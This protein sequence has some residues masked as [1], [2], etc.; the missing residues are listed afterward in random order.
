M[1]LVYV[2]ELAFQRVIMLWLC[3]SMDL[4]LQEVLGAEG[5]S[6]QFRHIASHLIW[7]CA[8]PTLP[9]N[10]GKEFADAH[11]ELLNEVI[12]VTG[13]FAVENNDNQVSEI[14]QS[15]FY[16]TFAVSETKN[17]LFWALV[18]FITH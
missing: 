10:S 4:L 11:Q 9:K 5:I 2:I 3:F 18:C 14:V 13:Y 12:S 17:L 7:C 6:L 16:V 15:R 8:S 1:S